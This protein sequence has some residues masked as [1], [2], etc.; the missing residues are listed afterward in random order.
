MTYLYGKVFKLTKIEN[1]TLSKK[2]QY[3]KFVFSIIA[4]F[5]L[6]AYLSLAYTFM[7][8]RMPSKKILHKIR[9][10]IVGWLE[11]KG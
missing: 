1:K 7:Y 5:Y 8:V 10:K 9:R 2:Y 11:S 3:L 4:G 6:Y